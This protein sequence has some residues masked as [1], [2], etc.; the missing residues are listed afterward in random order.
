MVH[1]GLVPE[2]Y[3]QRVAYGSVYSRI[4]QTNTVFA[5]PGLYV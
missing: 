3:A 1:E 4:L 5:P 2:K